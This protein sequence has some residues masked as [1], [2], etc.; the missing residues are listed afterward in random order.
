MSSTHRLTRTEG[1]GNLQ[2]FRVS[3]L[4]VPLHVNGSYDPKIGHNQFLRHLHLH[5]VPLR[6][7]DDKFRLG[8]LACSDRVFDF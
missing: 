2:I 7:H 8:P 4:S 6:I 3:S 5:T 1:T